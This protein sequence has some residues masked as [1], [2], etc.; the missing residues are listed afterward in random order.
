[1]RLGRCCTRLLLCLALTTGPSWAGEARLPNAARWLAPTA[2]G[3]AALLAD[4]SLITVTDGNLRILTTGFAVDAPIRNCAGTIVATTDD[5]RLAGVDAQGHIHL[6]PPARL[7]PMGGSACKDQ[8]VWSVSGSGEIVRFEASGAHWRERARAS[9]RALPDARIALVSF[10]GLREQ[11]LVLAEANAT[12]YRHGVLGDQLEALVIVML[13]PLTL[14]QTGRLELPA[15]AVFED[16][17]LRPVRLGAQALLATVR[18]TPAEGAA[19]VLVGHADQAL[20]IVAS[21]PPMGEP[22][23]W[24]NPLSGAQSLFAIHTP[25]LGGVL[26]RYRMNA[27]G[28][29]ASPMSRGVSNHRMGSRTLDSSLVTAEDGSSAQ[30]VMP[31]QDQSSLVALACGG[32]CIEQARYAMPA[33]L[34][35]NL[36]QIGRTIWAGSGDERLHSFELPPP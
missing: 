23:R 32:E 24:L 26:N 11:L 18:S 17:I 1:M 19:L 14:A 8:Q 16:L 28:L 13:D 4:G 3:V 29:S 33:P 36:L 21:G 12:R 22:Q 34:T 2:Q 6:S 25:H 30:L 15:P 35:S 7:S 20:Q 10:E 5:G 31:T 9:V 27:K